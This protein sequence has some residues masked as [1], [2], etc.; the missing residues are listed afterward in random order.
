[1]KHYRI[2]MLFYA[3]FI[4]GL[5]LS[6]VMWPAKAM[7]KGQKAESS[8]AGTE[9]QI[10]AE[11]MAKAEGLLSK[12]LATGGIGWD[13]PTSGPKAQGKRLIIFVGSDMTNG[14]VIAVGEGAKQAIDVIG[15]QMEILDGRGSANDQIAAL[16]QAIARKP[17]GIVIGGW[18]PS[19]ARNSLL[20]AE[21]LGIP[22]V[23]WH[24][25]SEPGPAPEFKLFFNITTDALDVA[26]TAA[27]YAI[28]HSKENAQSQV[29]AVVFTDSNYQIAIDKANTMRDTVRE[30]GG[31]ILEYIDTPIAETSSRMPT[32]T[33]RL[34]QEY[35]NNF[36][37]LAINDNY[38]TGMK[39]TLKLQGVKG[40]GPPY[41]IS[42]G[43]GDAPAF[44]RI[45]KTDYQTATVPEPLYM[46]GWQL[47]D[48]LNRALAGEKS[49]GYIPPVFVIEGSN[50]GDE[51]VYD[52]AVGYRAAY[53]RIWGK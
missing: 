3:A 11:N 40:G 29:R 2:Q 46:Q 38:F 10:S 5:V 23:G 24:A 16:N 14:G 52:P 27:L 42:A 15:W 50:I 47:V 25:T 4:F 21:E 53:R 48:E 49:S 34:L 45:R 17:D 43:D 51:D 6:P 7:A 33:S 13:G 44:A 31:K 30:F 36:Y 12:S 28:V 19:A 8:Q 18:Y 41:N 39:G 37:A 20:Q 9:G 22:I 32:L 35:G 26:R 1:M